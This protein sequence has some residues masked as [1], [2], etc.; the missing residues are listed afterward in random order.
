MRP[1]PLTFNDAACGTE[2]CPASSASIGEFI[3]W[4]WRD[5]SFSRRERHVCHGLYHG[6]DHE[7]H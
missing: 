6:L 1:P 4:W 3:H 5:G 7:C 2:E